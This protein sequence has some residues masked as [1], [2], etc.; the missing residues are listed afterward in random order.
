M[1]KNPQKEKGFTLSQSKGFTLI[2]L[3]LVMGIM[4][5]LFG[6]ATVNLVRTQHFASVSATVDQLVSDLHVQQTKAMM[7]TKDTAGNTNSYGIH[8]SGSTYILFQGTTDPND[9]SDFTV[10]PDGITFS[11]NLPN[12][13]IVFGQKSGE[14]SNYVS[15]PYAITVKNT[16]GT[17]QKTLYINKYG[18]VTTIQ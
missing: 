4:G 5:I 15:G 13:M 16:N 3:L 12:N 10:S 14:F 8:V 9:S 7:G 2:E 1:Q 18:V 17:E 6:L 11:T